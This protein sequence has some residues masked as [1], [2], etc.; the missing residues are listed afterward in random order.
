MINLLPQSEKKKLLKMYRFRTLALVFVA[1][2]VIEVLA[3]VLFLPAFY[4]L[5]STTTNLANELEQKRHMI[6]EGESSAQQELAVIKKEIAI[7]KPSTETINVLPSVI[8]TEISTQKPD[9][10]SISTVSYAR[11]LKNAAVQMSGHART[12]EDMLLFQKNLKQNPRVASTQYANNSFIIKKTDI[13]F[14]M[15]VSLK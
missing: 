2:L 7:L 6:P 9:G 3:V 12:S 5:D 15:T 13:D 8:F 1:T 11:N 14:I 10:I 4:V